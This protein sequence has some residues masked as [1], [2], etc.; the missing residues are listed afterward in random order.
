[1]SEATD[2]AYV[3]RL[4]S[5]ALCAGPDEDSA[6]H[7]V[8]RSLGKCRSSLDLDL[9]DKV[10]QALERDRAPA[11]EVERVIAVHLHDIVAGLNGVAAAA[12]DPEGDALSRNATWLAAD[13]GLDTAGRELL[14]LVLRYPQ[15]YMLEGLVDRL[16]EALKGIP[17]ALAYLLGTRRVVLQRLLLPEAALVR[18]GLV[19]VNVGGR[20]L[21]SLEGEDTDY[22][23]VSPDLRHNLQQSFDGPEALRAAI[24]GPSLEAALDWHDFAHLGAD[25][26]LIADVLGGA[27][28]RGARGVNLL[29]HGPPGCGKT[30]LCKTVAARL[31]LTLFAV[32]EAGPQ[33][34]ELRR[35]ERLK[36]LR[37]MQCLAAR[38][39]GTVLLFDEME[40]LQ[41]GYVGGYGGPQTRSKVF[42][43]RL[44]ETNPVPVLWTANEVGHFDPAILRRMTLAVE[45][46]VPGTRARARL[47]QRLVR[48]SAIDCAPE[49]LR[50]LAE[51]VEVAPGLAAGAVRAAELAEGGL[52]EIRRAADGMAR[53]VYGRHPAPA[54]GDGTPF[55]FRLVNA[56]LDLGVLVERVTRNNEIR[57]FSL[58]L[59]GPPGTGKTAFARH[60]A[61]AMGLRPLKKRTSDLLSMWIGG[62]E[63]RIARAFEEAR[64]DEAFLIFDEADAL[65]AERGGAERSW[66]LSQ[67]AEMLTWMEAHPLPFCCTTNLVERL[68]RASLRR[69]TFKVKFDHL[70]R[71][72]VGLAFEVFFGLPAP[73]GVLA[74]ANLTPGDFAVVRKKASILGHVGHAEA[75]ARM[76]EAESAAKPDAGRPIGFLRPENDATT[77]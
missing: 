13:L 47:W 9:P 58:C 63:K 37:L 62:T 36:A 52:A 20:Y 11:Q 53:A 70:T 71:A 60:L 66:E 46:K 64:E 10:V 42:F 23:Q 68:D 57:A 65:L 4:A 75:L 18:S 51:E 38:G 17:Q 40:D 16:S 43:N 34:G 30:E 69:F 6:C 72:Q 12:E 33:G 59:N 44:L 76:L 55:D 28:A 29:L 14:E 45:L 8:V 48:D 56:D 41:P 32:G 50:S 7:S 54:A 26:D 77:L 21:A 73:G 22:L 25:R 2:R 74:L 31:G 1:M 27:V 19:T 24:F 15:V 67:V 39:A 5:R 3:A 61:L 35:G 49:D